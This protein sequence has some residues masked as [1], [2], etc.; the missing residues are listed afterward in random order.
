MQDRDLVGYGATPPR[1]RWPNDARVAISLVVNYE[2]GSENLLQDGI[3]RREMMGEGPYRLFRPTGATSP[4][5]RF[6]STAAGPAS[7]ASADLSPS[8]VYAPR[9]SPAPSRWS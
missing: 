2:E 9:F 7:G 5:S 4:T 1:V 8:T 3:G 6:S